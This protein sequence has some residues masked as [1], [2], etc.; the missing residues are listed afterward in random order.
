MFADVIVY[1]LVIFIQIIIEHI[2]NDGKI[3]H[4]TNK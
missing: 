4:I 2:I 3:E 1:L